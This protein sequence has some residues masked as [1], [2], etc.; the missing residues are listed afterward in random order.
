MA[1][2]DSGQEDRTHPPSEK[3]LREAREQG[4]VPRSRELTTAVVMIACSGLLLAMAKPMGLRLVGVLRNALSFDLQAVAAAGGPLAQLG[5]VAADMFMLAVPVI[6]LGVFAA[7]AGTL[8]LGGINLAPAALLPKFDRIDPL[9]GFKRLYSLPALGEVFKSLLRLGVVCA[10]ATIALS[11]RLDEIRGLVLE[12]DRAGILHAL[13]IVGWTLMALSASL[14][15][16]AL[17][18]VPFQWWKH[19]RQLRMTLEEVRREM[20]ESE[21]N[22]EVKGRIRQMQREMSKRRMMEAVPGADVV[23]VNPTHYA[24]ALKYEQ[25]RMRAPKVVAKGQDLVALAIR[26]LAIKHKVPVVSAPP[27]ARALYGSVALGQ[28]IP[29]QLYHAVAQVLTF[30]F[31]LRAYRRHGGKEPVLGDIK[32]DDAGA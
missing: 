20:K 16:I 7:V 29:A 18:D 2:N 19:R 4:Q 25:G 17:V 26:E 22:P 10:V 1:D 12:P 28:E 14:G 32:V 8:G 31:Q 13:S 15:L 5:S 27:L 24:V 21:G 3:R 30:V 6:A 11:T 23:L 9:A